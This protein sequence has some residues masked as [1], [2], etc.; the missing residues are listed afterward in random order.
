[1]FGIPN[2]IFF[3]IMSSK[4]LD[5]SC[6]LFRVCCRYNCILAP[7]PPSLPRQND[8]ENLFLMSANEL[9][10]FPTCSSSL[11]LFYSIADS[12]AKRGYLI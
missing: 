9:H 11:Y 12:K 5:L 7:S 10:R 3:Y 8:P 1:M 4:F 2:I 6:N